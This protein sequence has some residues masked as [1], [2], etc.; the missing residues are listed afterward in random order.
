MNR[1]YLQQL[2][3]EFSENSPTNYLSAKAEDVESLNKLANNFYA[4]NFARNNYHGKE[5]TG[6]ELN[7][8][9]DSQYIG[10]RFFMPPIIAVGTAYDEGFKKLKAPEV[11]GPHHLM[12]TD[13]LPEAKSVISLF[14]PFTERVIESNTKDPNSP[15]WEWLFTRV[16]GQQHLLAT[17]ALVGDSLIQEGYKAVVPYSDDRF[18]M[19]TSRDQTELPIPAYS[20]NWSERHVGYITGLGTF[21]RSTNFISKQ[22][23][24]GRLISIITD[25][26]TMPDEKDY[27]DIYDYCSECGA[28]YHA[29][30]GHAISKNGKDI[31]KCSAYLREVGKKFAP[32]YGCGKCQSG[33]PCQIKSLVNPHC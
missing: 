23:A 31:D 30:P 8:D 15:S 33:I 14:L 21:G 11:V 13:W 20:S 22:G 27:H 5:S 16:D 26:K 12:P 17:G 19:R 28:C 29:C 9:K 4:N 1:E 24:C 6:T 25:W 2:T 10:M 7:K 18:F 3:A 32:R